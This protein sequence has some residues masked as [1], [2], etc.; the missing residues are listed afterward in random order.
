MARTSPEK[1]SVLPNIMKILLNLLLACL[2]RLRYRIR[3]EGLRELKKNSRDDHRPILFL[4]N[5]QALID[6]VIVMSL[7]WSRFRPRPLADEKQTNHPLFRWLMAQMRAIRIPDLNTGGAQV[8]EQ[9]FA[10]IEEIIAALKQ[11]DNVLLY[12]SG[13]ISRGQIEVI[14]G[15]SGAVSIV[16]AVPEA[17]IVLIRIRG[18]W[19]SRYSRAKGLPSLLKNIGGLLFAILERHPLHASAAGRAG[20]DRARKVSA[21]R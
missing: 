1:R 14:G 2:L 8:K 3:V 9:V 18:L 11:G 19:G 4:P 13:R 12:P 7:L 16:H 15:N 10:G 17:R 20:A 21:P 6:P 5:H